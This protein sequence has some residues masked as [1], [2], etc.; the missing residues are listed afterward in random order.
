MADFNPYYTFLGLDEELQQPN[1]YQLL[2]LAAGE[3]DAAK[4]SAAADKATG[5]VRAIRPGANAAAWAA[6]LD[7]IQTARACLLDGERRSAYD[8][9]HL[10]KEPT[11]AAPVDNT[12]STPAMAF[13]PPA[14]P[15]Y[16]FPPGTGPVATATSSSLF[17][18]PNY[19]MPPSQPLP[20]PS[21]MMPAVDPMAPL[22][23]AYQAAPAYAAPSYGYP[24]AAMAPTWPQQASSMLPPGYGGAAIPGPMTPVGASWGA[25]MPPAG[26]AVAPP[27][28]PTANDALNPMAP[29]AYTAAPYARPMV[30]APVELPTPSVPEATPFTMPS[31]TAVAVPY[32][33]A[34]PQGAAVALATPQS[35]VEIGSAVRSARPMARRPAKF[36]A[37]L[38][39][40]GGAAAALVVGLVIY[41]STSGGTTDPTAEGPGHNKPA[42]NPKVEHPT[43]PVVH[44]TPP[45]VQPVKPPVGTRPPPATTDPEK[46]TP[47]S[48]RPE[49][50]ETMPPEKMTPEPT[51]PEP[52]KPE[53][54]PTP[55][56]S[57]AELAELSQLLT[58]AKTALGDFSFKEANASLRKADALAKLQEHVDKVSRLKAIS[59][60]A[61][62]FQ[63]AIVTTL[64][65]LEA[66][67][68]IKVGASTEAAI[69]EATPQKL[70]I[71]VAGQN[72]TYAIND[73]PLGLATNLGERSLDSNAPS[74]KLLKGAFVF[75]DKRTTPEQLSKVRTWWQEAG[76]QG[77]EVLPVL[78]DTYD[79][80]PNGSDATQ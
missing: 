62:Q 16:A 57:P 46:M 73:L 10:G 27:V 6:L 18:T 44:S 37:A 7:E 38:I 35:D 74:T 8:R 32:E 79:F 76:P 49:K 53:P 12:G 52:T 41:V 39:G 77:R 28:A 25:P 33:S 63:K 26:P 68:V 14:A 34:L 72:R 23:Q 58:A 20:G 9:T 51:K 69:V 56:P 21:P 5:R 66:G 43:P 4:I 13:I 75:V 42:H 29:V 50:P 48:V 24:A 60:M 67:D 15:A 45:T 59:S 65:T 70:V 64:G 3:S 2:R 78:D 31:A 36:P 11:A 17:G 30:A 71:R 54:T 19:G 61:E 22:P 80:A 40:V 47:V 55:E 1:H